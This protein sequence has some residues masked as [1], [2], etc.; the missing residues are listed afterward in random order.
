MRLHAQLWLP[1][2]PAE[3]FP[4]FSEAGNLQKITPAW[5][6]FSIRRVQPAPIQQG[7][8]IDYRLRLHGVPLA[9]QS[10]ITLWEPPYRFRDEQ[11]QGPYRHWS[12]THTFVAE[13]G[14]TLCFDDVDYRVWGGSLVD[15][16]VVRRDLRRIFEYRQA[17]LLAH[18]TGTG[19]AQATAAGHEPWRVTFPAQSA[20]TGGRA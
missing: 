16:L 13:R 18:F 20:R 2:S 15:R 6:D 3:V 4:F 7:C 14:G 10:E 19:G 1:L 17:A 12:H 11:R 9:W 8:R 5:L